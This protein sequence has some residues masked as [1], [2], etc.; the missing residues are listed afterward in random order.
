VSRAVQPKTVE[1][2]GG[3]AAAEAPAITVIVPTTASRARGHSLIRAIESIRVLQSIG[4]MD[5]V[6]L[7]QR[8]EASLMP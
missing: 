3:A 8:P 4:A 6:R 1:T 5:G 7:M 2:R